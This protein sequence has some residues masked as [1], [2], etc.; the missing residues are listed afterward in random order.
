MMDDLEQRKIL[1]V[2]SHAALLLSSTVVAIAVPIVILLISTDPIVQVN[3]REA[4]NFS[5]NLL[6]Y[7]VILVVLAISL[8]GLPVAILL[9][10]VLFVASLILPIIAIVSTATNPDTP[11]RYPFIWHIV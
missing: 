6:I 2:I 8:I 4:I 10:C 7:G 5:I 11:Y 1:S 9:G 3:A